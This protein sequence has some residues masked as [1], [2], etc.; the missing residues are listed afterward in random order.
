MKRITVA[1]NIFVDNVKEIDVY[2]QESMLCHIGV[3]RRNVG[4]C[5]NNTAINLAIIDEKLPVFAAG[6]IGG[7]DNGKFILGELSGWGICTKGVRITDMQTGYT[8]VFHSATMGTRTFFNKIGAN[9]IFGIDDIDLDT[10]AGGI[11]H[12]GYILLLPALD[13]PDDEY[14]TKMARLLAV[15][16]KRGIKTSVDAVSEQGTRFAKRFIAIIAQPCGFGMRAVIRRH[17]I[18]Y[19]Q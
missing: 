14:G 15:A 10:A 19:R 18:L 12:I 4:G 16:R 1:G 8:D 3:E 5:V 11:L 6:N 9:A 7:D 17:C 2:P 13:A